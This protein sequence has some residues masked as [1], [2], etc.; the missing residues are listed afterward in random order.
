MNK[1]NLDYAVL[2]ERNGEERFCGYYKSIPSAE[3]IDYDALYKAYEQNSK[4]PKWLIDVQD[5]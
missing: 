4:M 1:C 2:F 5:N 3:E